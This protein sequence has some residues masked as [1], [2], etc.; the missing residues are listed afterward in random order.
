MNFLFNQHKHQQ[1]FTSIGVKPL[2]NHPFTLKVWFRKRP[3]LFTVDEKTLKVKEVLCKLPIIPGDTIISCM[4]YD[5]RGKTYDYYQNIFSN[6]ANVIWMTVLRA[7]DIF[8]KH[9]LDPKNKLQHPTQ[10][11]IY[12]ECGL[13]ILPSSEAGLNKA[14]KR[15]QNETC[16][17]INVSNIYAFFS[18]KVIINI[19]LQ[20][21]NRPG[22]GKRL[23]D[24]DEPGPVPESDTEPEPEPEPEPDNDGDVILMKPIP[25]RVAPSNSSKM[26]ITIG[27]MHSKWQE[28]PIKAQRSAVS[29]HFIELCLAQ[30]GMP[31]IQFP[32]EDEDQEIA[33]QKDS[34]YTSVIDTLRVRF[35]NI[36]KQKRKA[37]SLAKAKIDVED[38]IFDLEKEQD[39]I[40]NTIHLPEGLPDSQK[41][42]SSIRSSQFSDIELE[43]PIPP[44]A[45]RKDLDKCDPKHVRKVMAQLFNH[46]MECFDKWNISPRK[47]FCKLAHRA[48]YHSER[49]LAN[50]F[51]QIEEGDFKLPVQVPM[52]KCVYLKSHFI[53]SQRNW[54]DFRIFMKPYVSLPT[55]AKVTNQMNT[56]APE[57]IPF[58]SGWRVPIDVVAK[59]TLQSLPNEVSHHFC[60]F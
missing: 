54:T 12:C 29:N 10:H 4:G 30:S 35:H 2:F 19:F 31:I 46:N 27:E 28:Q 23:R 25:K 39:L 42:G 51:K 58:K 1:P 41:S 33:A 40:D 14:V 34:Q 21:S 20:D 45:P 15:L 8:E 9:C 44:P 59:E 56:M 47:G 26:I 13:I 55:D 48:F 43:H 7:G 57:L 24:E 16:N 37:G 32:C 50:T 52:D 5:L 6:H 18:Y 60:V 38:T 49:E 22:P 3:N 11:H 53:K 36:L 17:H